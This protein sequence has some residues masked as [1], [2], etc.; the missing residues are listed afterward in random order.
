MLNR[1]SKYVYKF[2]K[3]V[4]IY[5]SVTLIVSIRCDTGFDWHYGKL[6]AEKGWKCK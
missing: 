6:T 4:D 2:D 5:N 3:Y 1:S